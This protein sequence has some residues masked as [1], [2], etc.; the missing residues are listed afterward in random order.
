[1]ANTALS[2]QFKFTADPKVSN[3]AWSRTLGSITLRGV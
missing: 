2:Q 1:M 3:T